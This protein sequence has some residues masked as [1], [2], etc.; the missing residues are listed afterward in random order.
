MRTLS[1]NAVR[2]EGAEFLELAEASAGIGVWDMDLATGMVRGR[3][4]F[5]R[6]M[7]LDPGTE[8]VPIDVMRALRHPD[9]RANVVDGFQQSLQERTDYYESEYRILKDGQIRWILGRGRVVR[10]ERG[11]PVRYSGVDID[12]TERKRFE[13]SLRAA[14][15]RFLRVF[16]LAPIAMSIST[17]QEGRYID[18]NAALLAQAGYSREEMIGRTARQ[19]AVY[20]NE[21]DFSKVRSLLEEKGVVKNLEV[22][23]RGKHDARTVLLSADVLE[24]GQEQCL[25]TAS[26]DITERKTVEAQLLQS[27][28]RYR[29]LVDNAND[30]VATLDLAGRFTSINP[31]VERVLGYAPAELIGKSPDQLSQR[32][33]AAIDE[34]LLRRQLQ[35]EGATRYERQLCSKDGRA[36]ALEVNSKL[37]Y[38]NGGQ[39]TAVHSIYRD[40][41]ERKDAEARQLLLIRELQHRAK[42]LLA[43][44]QSIVSNT[45]RNSKDVQAVNTT[46]AGRL[47]ALAR[48]QE[49]IA[50]G[51]GGGAP[52]G[53]IVH[54]EL[55]AFGGRVSISGPALL[56]GTA[57]A[58]MFAIVVHE[59][60]TNAT[61]YGS[62]SVPE[63][64][65]DVCWSLK[66]GASLFFSWK[67]RRGPPVEPPAALGFGSEVMRV[68]LI[69]NP[70]ISFA[71]T[72]FE[73]EISVPLA[74]LR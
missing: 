21:D 29:N 47:Q 62:L 27:E 52:I 2:W 54:A 70:R 51:P 40:V 33:A 6:L 19:L 10:D 32:G 23:L 1:P 45:L 4:Q 55:S 60:A 28:Q 69:E 24:L 11:E 39:P 20:V 46:I 73:Y 13:E 58:Q 66:D 12:I 44:V 74:N 31:A 17:L 15:A 26:V 63:G 37:I 22:T 30:I 42:N 50:A 68:A 49:F 38:D 57:F 41:T 34:P 61:K 56:A 14:E 18:V 35:E 25:L 71:A 64:H 72:G 48:A 16:Q 9:D 65:V 43:I 36:L 7:G 59:L 3:P 5:F 8:Q 67:E 53:D